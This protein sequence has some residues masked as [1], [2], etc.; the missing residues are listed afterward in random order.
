MPPR[1]RTPLLPTL[2][3]GGPHRREVE[4]HLAGQQLLDALPLVARSAVMQ[5]ALADLERCARVSQWPVLLEGETGAGKTLF[6]R[7]LHSMRRGDERPFKHIIL[8][9]L[10]ASLAS[11]ELFGHVQGAYTDARTSRAGLIASAA[12]GTVFLD[13]IDKAPAEVLARLL[14]VI[15]CRE[16]TPVGAD[17]T[18]RIDVDFVAASNRPLRSLVEAGMFPADLLARFGHFVV[19][20]P[21]LRERRADIEELV[22][23]YLRRLGPRVQRNAPPTI[24]RELLALLREAPWPNNLRELES[25]LALMLAEAAGSDEL[26]ARHITG[27]LTMA[28]GR[29]CAPH[30]PTDDDLLEA[31]RRCGG[32]IP[33]AAAA[34]RISRTTAWRRLHR[35]GVLP[36]RGVPGDSTSRITTERSSEP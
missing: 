31:W 12:G 3:H 10:S 22:A 1:G 16:F 20:V 25:A 27:A 18:V 15:D 36:P 32:K 9:N 8:A 19:V 13:E 4:S 35:L 24:S 30:G 23:W 6:A 11:A 34:T 28:L 29:D 17:R 26:T 14:H 33:A 7:R 21:P 2:A 5:H